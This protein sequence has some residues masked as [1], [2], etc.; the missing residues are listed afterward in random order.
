MLYMVLSIATAASFGILFKIY[1]KIRIDTYVAII[2]NYLVAGLVGCFL[3]ES[4]S[5][6]SIQLNQPWVWFS[7]ILGASF[8]VSFNLIALSIQ[9]AGVSPTMVAA[10]MSLIF[11]AFSGLILFGDDLSIAGV[12]FALVSVLLTLWRKENQAQTKGAWKLPLIIFV[13]SGL[14]DSAFGFVQ[15]TYL[16]ESTNELFTI[17]TFFSA[18]ITGIISLPFAYKVDKKKQF[19][20]SIV[21]GIA[22]G[23]PNYF[24]IYFLLKTLALPGWGISV[25]FPV[26]NIGIV[27]SS[28]V[29]AVLFFNEKLTKWNFLG[30]VTSL[31]AIALLGT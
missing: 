28:V 31:I 18:F 19:I 15:K 11:P 16:T 1:E 24:S 20:K 26:L 5:I 23:I 17:A 22:L 13:M 8:F 7:T 12:L 9:K 29:V 25:V 4:L 30:I 14:Q 10:K 21:G 3:I 6:S 2:A 27:L